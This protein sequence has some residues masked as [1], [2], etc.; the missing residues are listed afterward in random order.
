MSYTFN[1][2]T[3]NLDATYIPV[4]ILGTNALVPG[5]VLTLVANQQMLAVGTF[6]LGGTLTLFGDFLIL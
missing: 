3:G 4:F 6:T 1:P 5:G 2:F